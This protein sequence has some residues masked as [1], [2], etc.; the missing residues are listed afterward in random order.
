MWMRVEG[1]APGDKPSADDAGAD[2]AAVATPS[3]RGLERVRRVNGR[4]RR[5]A[6]AKGAR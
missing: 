5:A 6:A 2:L 4:R 1:D 3:R